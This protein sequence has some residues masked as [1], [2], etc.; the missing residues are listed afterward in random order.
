MKKRE[1]VS[2]IM[3]KQVHTLN[4]SHSLEDAEKKFK[5]LKVRHLPVV[6][7]SK[8]VGIVSLTDLMRFSFVDSFQDDEPVDTSVYG[9]LTL[10]QV[11]NR[12]VETIRPETSIREAGEILANR[13]FHALPVVEGEKLV[14]IVTTTDLINYLL[15]QY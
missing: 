1:P 8:L 14:G 10:E 12:K 13:E 3:S 15:E 4:L 2:H 9:M 7:G 11:M 5:T 6:S